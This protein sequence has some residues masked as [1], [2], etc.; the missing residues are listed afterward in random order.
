[1]HLVMCKYH[2][3]VGLIEV[4]VTLLVLAV[5]LLGLAALQNSALRFNHTAYLESQAQFL[6][7]DVVESMRTTGKP[8]DFRINFG[9]PKP[10]GT[11]CDSANCANEAALATWYLEKWITNVNALLPNSQVQIKQLSAATKEYEIS[12][13]YDDLRGESGSGATPVSKREVVVVTRI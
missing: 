13:R 3:G 4:L 8:Q 1:M 5:G 12:I 2:K 7:R 10:N 11:D 9:D 6:I